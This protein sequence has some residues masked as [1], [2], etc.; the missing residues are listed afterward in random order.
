MKKIAQICFTLLVINVTSWA[1]EN[2]KT[3][4]LKSLEKDSFS[5]IVPLGTILELSFD[6]LDADQ[7][8]YSYKIT[9]MDYNWKPSS[10]FSNEY[11]EGF[12]ENIISNYDN[13]F[14]TLQNYTHYKVQIPNTNTKI[15]K[16][17]NYEISVLNEDNQIIFSRRFTL[18]ENK[19][20]VGITIKRGRNSFSNNQQHTVQ[21]TINYNNNQIK[22]PSRDIN[23]VI[24]QNKNWNTAITNIKPQFYKKDQLIYRHTNKTN[25]WSGNEY[26]N[27]DSKQ[28]RTSTIKIARAEK[29]DIYH[30]YLYT[31]D[32]REQKLYTHNPDING[33][34]VIRNIEGF[35]PN[36]EADYS[37][38][39]FS[40]SSEKIQ[41]KEVFIYG[42]FNN[43]T[44]SDLNKMTYNSETK[45][46]E[47]SILLKQGFYNY[48][49]VTKNT[50]NIIN[51]HEL[52][53]SF[54]QTENEYTVLVY[55]KAFGQY[56]DQV[57]GIGTIFLNKQ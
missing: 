50:N 26:L 49:F 32:R 33:Q 54:Y 47:A 4:Q 13:S 3:I 11:I 29:K 35:N 5:S 36:T 20:T 22:N 45:K 42:A 37:W 19:T 30:S 17:G 40:L 48:T 46:Y 16:S 7:K 57:I 52:N 41:N 44:I 15:I 31:E 18:Y 39:H 12:Q 24:L 51:N 8:E 10:I 23:V 38:V 14:N 53:G 27:F 28:L 43:F 6:D 55:F 1:Q 21:F 56:Y 34:F 2:I 9:H 25:F